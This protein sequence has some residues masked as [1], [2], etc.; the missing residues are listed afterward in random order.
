F[1]RMLCRPRAPRFPYTTLFRSGLFGAVVVGPK[2]SKYRDPKTGQDISSK[3]SWIAD[4]IVDRTI[5]GN[6][7]R[8][9]YR[10]AALFFQDEDNII[11]RKSTR[12]NSSHVSISYAVF[13]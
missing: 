3:N 4:V 13:C 8:G 1:I 9:N 6:E 10:D 5:Q 2:G 7:N 12:L 11:D